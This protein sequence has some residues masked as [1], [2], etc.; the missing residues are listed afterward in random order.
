MKKIK[1]HEEENIHGD[2]KYRFLYA[3]FQKSSEIPLIIIFLLKNHI[4]KSEAGAR[5]LVIFTIIFFFLLSFML[6]IRAL[7]GLMIIN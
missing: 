3:K 1:F 4:V 7:G 2:R 5:K 6:F